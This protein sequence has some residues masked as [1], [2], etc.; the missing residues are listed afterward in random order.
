MDIA[1]PIWDD[2][3]FLRALQSIEFI[4]TTHVANIRDAQIKLNF[5]CKFV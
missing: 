5:V 3:S 2:D 1:Q 4:H